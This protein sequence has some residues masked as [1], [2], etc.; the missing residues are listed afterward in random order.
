VAEQTSQLQS[1]DSAFLCEALSR[2]RAAGSGSE[3]CVGLLVGENTS[4]AMLDS[5]G[6]ARA[7]G[8]ITD[9]QPLGCITKVFTGA[10][11][12]SAHVDRCLDFDEGIECIDLH[13][14]YKE[15]GGITIRHLLNHTHGLDVTHVH[16]IEQTPE[17]LIDLNALGCALQQSRRLFSP[18][19]LYSYSNA[20]MWLTAGILERRYS[21]RFIDLVIS[22]LLRPAEI[23]VLSDIDESTWWCPAVGGDFALSIPEF[24]KFLRWFM[25]RDRLSSH[26]ELSLPSVPTGRSLEQGACAGWK[27]YGAGWYGHQMGTDHASMSFRA[28]LKKRIA[29]V[30][31]ARAAIATGVLARIFGEVIPELFSLKLPRPLTTPGPVPDEQLC[32]GTYLDQGM[33]VRVIPSMSMGLEAEIFDRNDALRNKEPAARA[34]LTPA[35]G[36]TY[37][38]ASPDRSFFQCMQ[39]LI[40]GEQGYEYLWDGRQ[41]MRRAG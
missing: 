33:I 13:P 37:L 7:E 9:R 16:H 11:A 20:G 3:I 34:V 4:I 41:V 35:T 28:H 19:V 17:R 27:Y 30:A 6:Q 40:R 18:G 8:T 5:T 12:L 1:Y 14:F 23:D 21:A 31:A 2:V 29:I 10:L 15:A 38:A 32:I 26:P 22:K 25:S 36:G 39:F 24:L